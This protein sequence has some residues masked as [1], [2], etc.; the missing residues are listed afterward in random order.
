M[1]DLQD[2]NET[3]FYGLIAGNVRESLPIVYT[4]TVGEGCQRFSE[5]WHKP[6]GLFITYP[7]QHRID[8]ILSRPRYDSVKCIVVSDGERILGTRR[9]GRWRNGHSHRENGSLYSTRRNPSGALS[10]NSA[11]CGN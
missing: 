8:Q 10:S 5:I 11:R 9:P 3:L 1:R 6:R 2:T 4:P 7:S